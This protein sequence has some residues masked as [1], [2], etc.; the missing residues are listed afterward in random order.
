[1]KKIRVLIVDDHKILREGLIRLLQAERDMEV[2]GEAADGETAIQMA[3]NLKPDVITMDVN[4]PVIS[5]IEATRRIVSEIPG[6]RVIGLSMDETEDQETAMLRA[7]AIE[8]LHKAG[9]SER[10]ITAIRTLVS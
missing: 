8:Y 3:R 7:G 5:G 9:P 1:M 6:I 2:V 10:L 4:L